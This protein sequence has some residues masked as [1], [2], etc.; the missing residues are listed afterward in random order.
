MEWPVQQE[1]EKPI[2]CIKQSETRHILQLDFE[3]QIQ[4]IKQSDNI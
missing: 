2:Q 3:K 1:C 4:S